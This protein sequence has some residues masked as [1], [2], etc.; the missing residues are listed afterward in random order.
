MEV[1]VKKAWINRDGNYVF[2]LYVTSDGAEVSVPALT[3][4]KSA[5]TSAEAVEECI[6]SHV[7]DAT[8]NIVNDFTGKTFTVER[9]SSWSV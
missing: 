6:K 7:L 8:D 1:T 2:D 9:Q 3:L 5:A 4:T